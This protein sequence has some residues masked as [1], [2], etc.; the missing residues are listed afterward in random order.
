[1]LSVPKHGWVNITI[2]D[3]TD[4]AS[5]LTD[6]HLDILDALILH[7]ENY[8]PACAKCDAEGWEYI[9]VFDHTETH[10]ITDK[11]ESDDISH[12]YMVFNIPVRALA[13][14]VYSDILANIRD[15]SEWNLDFSANSDAFRQN[16]EQKI[17]CKLAQLRELLNE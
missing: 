17:R 3:W 8:V 4:R 5:Y 1:M 16:E 13:E 11:A 10:I 2:G 9:I 14:E 15:W 6:V 12:K 7:F